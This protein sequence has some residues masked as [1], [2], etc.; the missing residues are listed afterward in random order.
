MVHDAIRQ[1]QVEAGVPKL[2]AAAMSRY[3][4][5]SEE[6]L[7]AT[8]FSLAV[9]IREGGDPYEPATEAAVEA[10]ILPLL[11]AALRDYEVWFFHLCCSCHLPT[12]V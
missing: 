11:Q 12:V 7:W 10:G 4:G 5:N 3:Q 6:V 2:I 1:Q 9:L 8:L